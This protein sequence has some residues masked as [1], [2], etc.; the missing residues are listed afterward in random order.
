MDVCVDW[1]GRVTALKYLENNGWT[2]ACVQVAVVS[3]TTI[4]RDRQSAL[5]ELNTL[6]SFFGKFPT[7]PF[8]ERKFEDEK[9]ELFSRISI[10][11][12]SLSLLNS[13][14]KSKELLAYDLVAVIPVTKSSLEDL[15]NMIKS[16]NKEKLLAFDILQISL[17]TFEF[18]SF[19]LSPQDMVELRKAQ[20]FVEFRYTE[21]LPMGESCS[22]TRQRV[23]TKGN[24]IA[25]YASRGQ[26][27]A[28]G[29][30]GNILLS[31]GKF[32]HPLQLRT[33]DAVVAIG[34]V[35]GLEGKL[36]SSAVSTSGQA[37]LERAENRRRRS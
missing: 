13:A 6:N 31:S 25:Q 3:A 10:S 14:L 33:P 26:L 23:I 24:E 36:A 1:N 2:C 21:A 8:S 20:I 29:L 4:V 35:L 19:R 22:E 7:V 28:K 16:S 5:P 27:H 17:D 34:M 32:Q 9:F 30:F 12:E 15:V 11:F 37:V 18:H